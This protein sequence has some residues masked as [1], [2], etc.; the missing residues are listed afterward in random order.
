MEKHVKHFAFVA[1]LLIAATSY[2]NEYYD[3]EVDGIYYGINDD[4]TSV[5]VGIFI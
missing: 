1:S 5:Y 4:G 2:A 3:L